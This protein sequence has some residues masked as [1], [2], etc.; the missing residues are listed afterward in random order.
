MGS[1][2]E[3]FFRT[4]ELLPFLEALQPTLGITKASKR[5]GNPLICNF[6][7]EEPLKTQQRAWGS[8]ATT[9]RTPGLMKGSLTSSPSPRSCWVITDMTKCSRGSSAA[10]TTSDWPEERRPIAPQGY[11]P[12]QPELTVPEMGT[13]SQERACSLPSGTDGS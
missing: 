6:C 12:N 2:K 10:L 8:Q 13:D 9:L 7:S 5:E 3:T 11:L 4:V 1:G